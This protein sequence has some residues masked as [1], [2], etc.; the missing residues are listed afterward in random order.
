MQRR[1]AGVVSDTRL[2]SLRGEP[3][4]TLYEPLSAAHQAD[5]SLLVKS[6]R[7]SRDIEA[8]VRTVVA[9]IDPSLALYRAEKLTVG[10]ARSI[11]T[12][13]VYAHLVG[14]LAT[15][16]AVLA[17]VG[18]YSVIAYSVAERT[19]EIGIRMALGAAAATIVGM[20]VRQAS[21]VVVTGLVIGVLLAAGI[22][23]VLESRLFGVAPL[24][25]RTYLGAA[26]LLVV[27]GAIASAQPARLATR[28]NPVDALRHD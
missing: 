22:S 4:P 7:P 5:V 3:E 8:M 21:R 18:L 10:V 25:V 6:D 9:E 28:V 24:D 15:L 27:L 26:V 16:A 1:V 12:E 11:S 14:I 19:R 20:V 23:R 17:A 2:R 13:R